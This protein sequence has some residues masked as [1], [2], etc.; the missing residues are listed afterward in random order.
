[1]ILLP[2]EKLFQ[3]SLRLLSALGLLDLKL[4]S[5]EALDPDLLKAEAFRCLEVS[6]HTYF[7]ETLF[8][9][10]AKAVLLVTVTS[11]VLT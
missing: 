1:M 6:S 5:R 9:L 8:W 4:S 7:L 11:A 3:W 2:E 10:Q